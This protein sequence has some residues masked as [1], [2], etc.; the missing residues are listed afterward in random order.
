MKLLR[1]VPRSLIGSAILTAAEREGAPVPG[2][3][4]G[5]ASFG[6]VKL[7][8]AAS[9]DLRGLVERDEFFWLDLFR[10][11][12]DDVARL[13]SLI[14]LDH[15]ALEHTLEFGRIPE[16]RRYQNHVELVFFGAEPDDSKTAELIEVHIYVSGGWVVT[17]RQDE[18]AALDAVR[19]E[20]QQ[21][22]PQAESV[23]V[24]RILDS[25]ADTFDDLLDPLDDVLSSIEHRVSE[26]AG[27]PAV[28]RELRRAILEHRS[29]LFRKRRLVRRQ[30]DY[31]ERTISEIE[32]LP[33][34]EPSQRHDLRDV[35]GQMIRVNDRVDD[36]LDRLAAALD[37]L[38]S[39]VSN[40]LN[41]IME[42]LT[43]VATIFL[44]LTTL[45]GF[46]GM[47]F[48]W[49]VKE[50]DTPLAFWT[51]GVGLVL[52]SGVGVALWV[53]RRIERGALDD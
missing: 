38:N 23:V 18:C 40:R 2:L 35:S 20:I 14:G 32:D 46:F 47:N 6:G 1:V 25:L 53:A 9:D 31:I 37:L 19:E 16:I 49:L 10:P 29:G 42:R 45:T 5:P 13:E 44:P 50:I 17:I 43:V 41:A 27:R 28:T 4:C 51:L 33:G 3:S 21:S 34:L 30:R 22:P 12:P 36:A 52:G 15:R 26:S 7:L 8:T 48:A 11:S 24:A 39:T